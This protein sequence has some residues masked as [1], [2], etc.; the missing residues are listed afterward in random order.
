[1]SKALSR[2]ESAEKLALLVDGIT[3]KSLEIVSE[4]LSDGGSTIW[5][6][7]S[8]RDQY[9]LEVYKQTMANRR[10]RMATE[11]ALGVIVLKNRMEEADWEKR[12]AEVDAGV[13][14]VE[15][16]E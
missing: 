14:D 4:A 7:R 9:A 13:I 8:V 6:D 3:A 12:A 5:N 15:P 2:A 16:V 1:M 11:R 10:E